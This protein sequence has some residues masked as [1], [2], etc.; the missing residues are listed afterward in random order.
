MAT[1]KDPCK[2]I[3]GKSRSTMMFI[4]SLS[5]TD[6][7]G[8]DQPP[9]CSTGIL[10]PKKDKKTIGDIK[11]AIDAACRKKGVKNIGKTTKKFWYPLIDSEQ[12]IADGEFEPDDPSIYK[13]M[14]FLRAKAYSLPGLVDANNELI[15]DI[16]DRKDMCVSGYYFRFSITFK[17]FDKESTGAWCQLNNVMFLE[18]GERLDGGARADK[19][20]EEYSE[21][22]DDEDEYDD[23][24]D[25]YDDDEDEEES[26]RRSRRSKS[27]NSKSRNSNS[28]RSKSRSFKR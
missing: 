3:T 4:N 27:R 9:Q 6:K 7:N 28:R 12:A 2:V 24:E 13:G 23:D 8:A 18:E 16:D 26:S 22:D 25:E 10:I 5:D 21:Y 15:E 20:F 19:D 17:G 14:Y 1:S 11:K